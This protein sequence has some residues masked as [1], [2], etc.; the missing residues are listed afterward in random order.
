MLPFRV[1]RSCVFCLA[2]TTLVAAEEPSV[3]VARRLGEIRVRDP[4][5]L[6]DKATQTYFLYA[7][8]DN[9]LDKQ[10]D[11]KGVEVYTSKDLLRWYGPEPACVLPDGSWADLMVWA[12]EVH[13]YDDKYY[14]FVTFTSRETL[15][16]QSGRPPLNKRGTQVLVSDSPKGPFQ[17]FHNRAHTP[18]QWMALDGTLWVEDGVAWMVFCHEWVQVIDGTMELVALKQDLSDIVGDPVTLF[19]ASEA[20]WVRAL[21][22]PGTAGYGFVT[23][24]P[25][26]YRTRTGKLLMIWSSFGEQRYAVGLAVSTTGKVAGP[27]E[28]MEKPLFAADGGHGMIFETFDGQLMLTLHQPN[29]DRAERARFFE[30]RDTGDSL[31]IVE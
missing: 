5:I 22:E 23:D 24:G 27:W 19:R 16:P 13:Q 17:P 15:P 11:R 1:W 28:Q 9:R 14:L 8:M 4:F 30:L 29:S 20:K 26:L 6:A 18:A 2:A 25:F 10:D 7:Q 31:E 3:P 12:P 21:G